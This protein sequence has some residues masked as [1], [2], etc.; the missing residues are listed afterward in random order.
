MDVSLGVAIIMFVILGICLTILIWL[1]IESI[2]RHSPHSELNV[3]R[4]ESLEYLNKLREDVR[5]ETETKNND[6][7]KT[8]GRNYKPN[9]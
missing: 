2:R 3:K 1:A 4:K 5:Q 8:E 7:M 9:V 6:L